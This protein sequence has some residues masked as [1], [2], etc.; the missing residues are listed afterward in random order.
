M[1]KSQWRDMSM[2]EDGNPVCTYS[3]ANS[4]KKFGFV[5]TSIELNEH[6]FWA[7]C[8]SESATKTSSSSTGLP[9][10]PK[11]VKTWET[12]VWRWFLLYNEKPIVDVSTQLTTRCSKQGWIK[13]SETYCSTIVHC[14]HGQIRQC[15]RGLTSES[16][17]SNHSNLTEIHLWSRPNTTVSKRSNFRVLHF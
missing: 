4:C 14:G 10:K 6:D 17:T 8:T 3:G 15:Q 1:E 2:S 13:I 7:R 16:C 11:S 9:L 5:T 12:E